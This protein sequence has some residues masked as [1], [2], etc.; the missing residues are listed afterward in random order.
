MALDFGFAPD[1]GRAREMDRN[2][3]RSVADSLQHI[4]EQ[5]RGIIRFDEPSLERMIGS[6]RQGHRYPPSLFGIYFEI[7]IALMERRH[8][9]A[10]ELFAELLGETPISG[11]FRVV[12]LGGAEIASHSE[13]Y[14]SLMDSDPSINLAMCPPDRDTELR[15]RE[16][17][18]RGYELLEGAAPELAAE[19]DALVSEVCIVVGDKSSPLQFDGGSSYMLWG[20]LFLNAASHETDV[21][22][23]E[24]L[25]HESAH[26]L[27]F[28]YTTEE[29]LVTNPDEA[30]YDSPLRRDPRPM[31]GIFH[32]TYVSAR[33]HW[34]L[35][36]LLESGLLDD[37]ARKQAETAREADRKNFFQGYEVVERHAQ[38]TRTGQA[39][40]AE[41]VAYMQSVA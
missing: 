6:L 33:M 39:V 38:L 35:S 16:R 15:F 29:T 12:A 25:A 41:A 3:R 31:D 2:V 5:S 18:R 23:A 26:S 34:A 17:L 28:G 40:M 22:M 32:A 7:V 14:A 20:G 8:Q 27:L 19:F 13:R 9:D 37:A 10:E 11:K 1:G 30:L 36:R 24:V 4:A 21:A